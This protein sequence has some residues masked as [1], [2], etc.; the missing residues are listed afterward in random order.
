MHNH[1]ALWGT[2]PWKGGEMELLYK[3]APSP[4]KRRSIQDC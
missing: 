2:P 3:K 4:K 1:P